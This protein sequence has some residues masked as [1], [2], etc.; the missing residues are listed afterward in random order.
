MALMYLNER[1]KW[2][3][4]L[5]CRDPRCDPRSTYDRR[6]VEAM[7]VGL[8]NGDVIPQ[9]TYP[10]QGMPKTAA[11]PSHSGNPMVSMIDMRRA[12]DRTEIDRPIRAALFL[13]YGHGWT[14]RQIAAELGISQTTVSDGMTRAVGLLEHSLN[15]T[16]PNDEEENA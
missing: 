6:T 13:H 4:S 9:D 8:W 10:E 15:G 1:C 2:H 7:L 12:W 14:T 16:T 3:G 5:W 11:D